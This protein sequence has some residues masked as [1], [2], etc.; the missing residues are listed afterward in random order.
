MTIV[1]MNILVALLISTFN[2]LKDQKKIFSLQ[3]KAKKIRNFEIIYRLIK[4]HVL[5]V[6]YRK[7]KESRLYVLKKLKKKKENEKFDH[8]MHDKIMK[9]V[10]MLQTLSDKFDQFQKGAEKREYREQVIYDIVKK[11]REKNGTEII[12]LADEEVQEEHQANFENAQEPARNQKSSEIF[13][14][15]SKQI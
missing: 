13:S 10:D 1:M 14:F 5:R 15:K 7:T 4:K 9:L 11:M 2:D 8:M 3:N 6:N 12:C